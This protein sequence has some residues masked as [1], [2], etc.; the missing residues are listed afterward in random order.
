M[1]KFG[2]PLVLLTLLALVVVP[3]P[4]FAAAQEKKPD[5][6]PKG[7]AP[8]INYQALLNDRLSKGITPEKNAVVLL[9][10]ALGPTPEGGTTGMPPVFFKR[11]GIEEPPKEGE[12]FI[13]L[14]A[15][16]KDHL[17]L[18]PAE[19]M[20]FYDQQGGATKRP[21]GPKDYPHI[22]AWL[23][24]NEK[25]LALVI[26]ATKRPEYYNPLIANGTEENPGMLIGALLPAVQKCR[27]LTVA[28]AAR[29]MLR[30]EEGKFE[31]AWQDLLACHRLARLVARGGTG[32][33]ALVG[34]AI[35]GMT[36]DAN[37]AYLELAKLSSKQIL[38][39]L[40]DLQSLSPM[41]SMADKIDLTERFTYLQTIQ[42]IRQGGPGMFEDPATGKPRKPTPEELKALEMIDWESALKDG[43][44]W[45][46]R[47]VAALRLKDRVEREKEFDKIEK[48]LEALLKESKRDGS[49]AK[50][51]KVMDE[52]GKTVGKKIGNTLI[53]LLTPAVRKLQA[54]HDRSV[55]F[56]RNRHLAFVLAAYERDNSRY[57]A[58]LAELS[59]KYL[60]IVPDD[61]FSGKAL[62]YQP[63][64]KGYLLYSVGVNGKDDGGRWVDDEPP[65][66]D[67]RVRMPLPPLK[68]KK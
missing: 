62:I 34:I 5:S 68:G 9:W 8:N 45:Y 37:L 66:D 52:P 43:N 38:D 31:A 39:C 19:F 59:P 48:E 22:A 1:S 20:T 4:K 46:D 16:L 56:E 40:K 55:Q 60:A 11:L 53:A 25:P 42:F 41:P 63:S 30:T 13:G 64:E 26:E 18:D 51:L 35:D 32:I 23:K 49:L 24:I 6:E 33:E 58:K 12:Y 14:H 2:P 50:L 27:E 61:L 47:M 54:A 65:G 29:A 57:P 44:R 10:K 7:T 17:R 3:A 15:Y 28:L 21:W 67:L 36:N